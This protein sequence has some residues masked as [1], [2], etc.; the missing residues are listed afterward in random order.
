VAR[1][2]NL[3]LQT[4]QLN[5][6]LKRTVAR[7]EPA[8]AQRGPRKKPVKFQYATQVGVRPPTIILFCTAPDAVQESYRRFLENR[9]REDFD[10]RGTPVRLRLRARSRD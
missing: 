6:W 8:M 3:R 4:A 1:A 10:L 2:G 5:R 9:L 7:H